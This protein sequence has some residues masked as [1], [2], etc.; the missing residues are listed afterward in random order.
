MPP[1]ASDILASVCETYANLG[2]YRDVG[3]SLT[4]FWN[5]DC[6][7]ITQR[8]MLGI[9][10][11]YR[12]PDHFYFEF[13]DRGPAHYDS[14][15]HVVWMQGPR[16]R[17][18]WSARWDDVEE[19]DRGISMA[20]AGATGISSGTACWIGRLLRIEDTH[21]PDLAKVVDAILLG[22]EL[23]ENVPCWHI[24]Y[25]E[26]RHPPYRY[27]IWIEKG[28]NLIRRLF[29][30]VGEKTPPLTPGQIQ[31]MKA[32]FAER[33]S[34]LGQE[35]PLREAYKRMLDDREQN[36]P[37]PHTSQTIWWRPEANPVL[38][39]ADFEFDPSLEK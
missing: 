25:A 14:S 18:W 5:D 17:V 36:N 13:R 32:E 27:Q 28:S 1:S 15:K 33:M 22:E 21:P 7:R 31:L 12:R 38:T 16:V 6:T 19:E 20:I 26:R 11:R 24:E 4:E 29:E 35:D 37:L 23:I 39:D 30:P 2:S 10:T 8:K 3:E 34:E 9:A